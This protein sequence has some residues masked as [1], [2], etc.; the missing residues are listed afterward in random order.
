MK[1]VIIFDDA[2][3]IP[4]LDRERKIWVYLPPG[5]ES[6]NRHYPVLYMHDGQNLFDNTTSYVGEWGI[7][8]IM[9]KMIEDGFPGIIIVGIEHGSE[10]RLNEYSPWKHQKMGGGLGDK[11]IAFLVETLKPAI[12]KNFRTL[13]DRENTGIGGSSMGGLISCY[14]MLKHPE[15]FSRGIIFSPAFWFSEESYKYAENIEIN[16]ELRMYFLAGGKEYGDLNVIEATKKMIDILRAK[17]LS[18]NQYHF[19]T[20]PKGK[21][22]EAF[23]SKYFAEAV[24]F[25]FV[26]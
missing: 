22:T 4:Q 10:E 12:D 13:P 26:G 7:D 18:E 14:A 21:H 25:L 19:K 1:N 2:F 23:W 11:H 17:G 3:Y 24:R 9:N 5:Y 16:N 20:D 15:I 8:E 6:S